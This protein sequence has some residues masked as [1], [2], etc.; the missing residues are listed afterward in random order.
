M[1]EVGKHQ[2]YSAIGLAQGRS[3][4][5]EI[6]SLAYRYPDGHTALGGIDLAVFEGDRVAL[7][8]HNGAGKTTLVKHLNGL[9]RAQSGT[10]LY[11]G[12]AVE[13]EHLDAVRLRVG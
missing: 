6:R 13:G 12:K 7:V 2:S 3:P 1:E 8:G 5:F 11:R 9:L 10:V 4:L